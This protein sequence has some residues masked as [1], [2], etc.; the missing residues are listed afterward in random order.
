MRPINDLIIRMQPLPEQ[1]KRICD[2]NPDFSQAL[3]ITHPKKFISLGAVVISY[4]PNSNN[5]EVIGFF[6]YDYGLKPPKFK[7]DF[8]VNV[9]SASKEFIIYT[10]H[11]QAT[12]SRYIRD[13][14]QFFQKY[15]TY[16]RDSHHPRFKEIPDSIKPR[17]KDAKELAERI[18]TFGLREELTDEE[19]NKFDQY[20]KGLNL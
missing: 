12:T 16:P 17:A 8:I 18:M 9:S 6:V 15:P 13:I 4:P 20:L 14:N 19:Y 3:K 7:Q 5:D 2:Q 1:I 11:R 10:R